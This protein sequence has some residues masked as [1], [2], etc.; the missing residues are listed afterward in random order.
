MHF[1][2]IDIV[3]CLPRWSRLSASQA[4]LQD[5]PMWYLFTLY[6]IFVQ[7]FIIENSN[8]VFQRQHAHPKVVNDHKLHIR[9]QL[10]VYIHVAEGRAKEALSKQNNVTSNTL[11]VL[12]RRNL[13][14]AFLPW[15]DTCISVC[16]RST[17]L[18][19]L[20]LQIIDIHVH[21]FKH[22]INVSYLMTF[23]YPHEV[24]DQLF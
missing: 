5:Y 17:Y 4:V 18:P 21:E 2:A 11:V 14:Y 16:L 22:I 1:F 9:D 15:G 3:D 20:Q 10:I 23:L 24:G 13:E 19:E 6:C 12:R 7:I 8:T